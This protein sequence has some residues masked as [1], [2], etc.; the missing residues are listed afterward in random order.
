MS[1]STELKEEISK[2]E[3]LSNKENVKYYGIFDE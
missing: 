2:S 3:K 1:F